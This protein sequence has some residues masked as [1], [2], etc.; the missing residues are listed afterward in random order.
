VQK[1]LLDYSNVL[2]TKKKW[3]FKEPFTEKL[4]WGTQKMVL[5]NKS[6]T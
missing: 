3:F 5:Q 1:A 4:F 6:I 2:H